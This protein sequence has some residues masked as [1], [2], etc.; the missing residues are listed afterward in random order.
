[1]NRLFV[2]PCAASLLAGFV[3]ASDAGAEG[4]DATSPHVVVVGK[5]R[6]A[7]PSERLDASR[8]GQTTTKIPV[9]PVEKWRRHLGGNID[10][11]PVVDELGRVLVA[12]SL[13]EVVALGADGKEVFRT[14]IGV[15]PAVAAPVLTSDGTLVVVTGAGVAVGVNREGRIRYATPL[16]A[17]GRD[18]EVAPLA[19]SDGSVV[20]GGRTLIELDE[21]GAIRARASLPERAV[22]ALLEGP[23]GTIITAESGNVY[24]FRSPSAPRKV[25]TFGGP[26]RRG[27]A[28]EGGRTLLAV[29]GG[30]TVVGL[31]LPTG[32]SHV[33]LGDVGLGTYDEPVTIHPKGFLMVTTSTGFLFGIDAAGNEK[34]R[35]MLDK[36]AGQGT[37]LPGQPPDP[38]AGL[39]GGFFG[40]ATDARPSPGLLV[41]AAG[42]I[43][44]ARQ[45]G[46]VGVA[47][48]DGSIS[49][50][51]ERM[52]TNPVS[53]QPAG[54]E[55][56]VVACRDGTVWMMGD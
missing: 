35:M 22:G 1:L 2:I 19:R 5:P 34:V 47:R 53:I 48:A 8:S 39:G 49:V 31:D 10:L 46:R 30:R 20:M 23:E 52:C 43:A 25:G 40:T 42:R 18:L 17:R 6:G 44:F 14:R 26:L 55:K 56:L 4:F 50:V 13:P 32:L 3:V 28:L 27:A 38:Q 33:R 45:G 16:G 37:T 9:S 12:L 54:E 41:D 36:G 7:A 21:T 24:V 29:V 51:G 11:P 15:S